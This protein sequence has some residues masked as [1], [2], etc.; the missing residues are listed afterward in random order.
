MPQILFHF[1]LMFRRNDFSIRFINIKIAVVVQD[2]TESTQENKKTKT[3]N[4]P[5]YC[6]GQSDFTFIRLGACRYPHDRKE[7]YTPSSFISYLHD[8][9]QRTKFITFIT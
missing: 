6:V 8:E 1:D 5:Y 3:K 4:A 9:L 7:L 2:I